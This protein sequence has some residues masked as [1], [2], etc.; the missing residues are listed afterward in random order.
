VELSP[1]SQQLAGAGRAE[2]SR[3]ARIA[4]IRAEI[5]AGRYDTEERFDAAID[6]LLDSI[7]DGI[8]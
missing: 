3:L 7:A 5:Q 1:A 4:Q 2:P 6:R 8:E